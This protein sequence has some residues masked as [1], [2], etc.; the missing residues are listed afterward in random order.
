MIYKLI[1]TL[2]NEDFLTFS[3]ETKFDV[4]VGNPPYFV[5]RYQKTKSV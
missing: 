1:V 3:R 4:I 5:V 2:Y